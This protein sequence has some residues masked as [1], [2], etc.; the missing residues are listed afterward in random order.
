[1]HAG[2]GRLGGG[3]VGYSPLLL[4]SSA[5][6]QDYEIPPNEILTF[7][8]SLVKLYPIMVQSLIYSFIRNLILKL[9]LESTNFKIIE[10]GNKGR[11]KLYFVLYFI[12]ADCKPIF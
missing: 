3:G 1:M 7:F 12:N 6:C 9:S 5:R 4:A 2:A 8:M 11:V 10:S